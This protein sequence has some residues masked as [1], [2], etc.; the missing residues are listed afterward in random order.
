MTSRVV[1]TDHAFADVCHE[2]EVAEDH[3][4]AFSVHACQ[5]ESETVD[6]VRGADVALVNFAP[7]TRPVLAAMA[8]RATVVRYGVGVDNVDL[9][10]A[11]TLGVTVANVPDY[12]TETVADHAAASLLALARRLPHYDHG[13][14]DQGWVR[15]TEVGPVVPLDRLVVGLVGMGRIAEAVAE[16]LA[17]FG[18]GFV[19]HDPYADPERAARAG[20]ELVDLAELA[21]RAHAI[22]LHA[23]STPETY[24]L[25]DAEF[26]AATRPGCFI[27]NT[28]RGQLVDHDALVAAIMSGH[29]SGAALD[30][31]DP[32]P[33]EESSPLRRLPQVLLTPHAAFYDDASLERLQRLAA[34][35]AGRALRGEPLRCPVTR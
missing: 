3:G 19:A 20:V 15:P 13:I 29:V 21:S 10:A 9:D 1:V 24:H 31:T 12:G 35:E 4:A 28:A 2:R 8:P 18:V 27:V 14:R 5:I 11:R 34:E 7:M 25:V 16:R 33:L 30:V 17:P 6:A 22:S 26:L 23:A 32:E